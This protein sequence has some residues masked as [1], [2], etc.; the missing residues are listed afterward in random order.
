[1][2]SSIAAPMPSRSLVSRLR[3]AWVRTG[4]EHQAAVAKV[5][6]YRP[7]YSPEGRALYAGFVA[8]EQMARQAYY[9]AHN[10]YVS[11]SPTAEGVV[12][13]LL[14]PGWLAVSP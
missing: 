12:C 14:G 13:G 3:A 7:A 11:A 8:A 5:R 2:I 4:R 1:M 6:V 10:A 9:A